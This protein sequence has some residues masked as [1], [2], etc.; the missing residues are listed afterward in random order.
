MKPRIIRSA[1]ILLMVA[2]VMTGVGLQL[3][4]T[5]VFLV[6]AEGGP[7]PTHLE[8]G[9]HWLAFVL[10]AVTFAG[11]L[12]VVLSAGQPNSPDQTSND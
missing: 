6:H 2:A 8:F 4:G 7:L 5:N 9:F 3:A 12:C 11:L 1:G 10:L